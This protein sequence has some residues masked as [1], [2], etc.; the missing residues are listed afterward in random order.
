MSTSHHSYADLVSDDTTA[1]ASAPNPMAPI[2]GAESIFGQPEQLYIQEPG[3]ANQISMNDINQGSWGDCYLLSAID[4]F[5]RKGPRFISQDITQNSNGTVTVK[6]YEDA[7]TNAPITEMTSKFKAVYEVVDPN[8]LQF[9]GVNT[10]SPTTDSLNGVKEI[11]PQV[12][13]QAYAQLNG[14][15]ANV[16]NGGFAAIAMAT[17]SGI[18][19]QKAPGTN[20]SN[21]IIQAQS[22]NLPML[23]RLINDNCTIAF[24]TNSFGALADG[25]IADHSYAYNG[26]TVS[27]PNGANT[28]LN[29]V[30]PWGPAYGTTIVPLKDVAQN[31]TWVE[32]GHASN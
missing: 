12:V 26:C 9:G 16:A 30:N 28:T 17:L 22:L 24:D 10:L 31:F 21:N 14:G 27:G 23:Q 3:D 32:V 18:D 13:E 11:W 4:T 6:L 19:G 20:V 29:L 5:I 25:L 7:Q 2:A 15:A 1:G 8:A